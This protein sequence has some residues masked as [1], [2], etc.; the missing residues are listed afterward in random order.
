MLLW[1]P[2][3][4]SSPAAPGGVQPSLAPF[5][6][7]SGA[8][9]PAAAGRQGLP[10][11]L[12][13]ACLPPAGIPMAQSHV[14]GADA[15]L[16]TRAGAGVTGKSLINSRT[17]GATDSRARARAATTVPMDFQAGILRDGNPMESLEKQLICPIC[18]EMFSKP[19]VILPCQHNLCRKCANDVFQVRK[20]CL[21]PFPP[22]A[23]VLWC[24]GDAH[25]ALEM[26]AV[27]W[28]CSWTPQCASRRL[29]TRTGRAGAV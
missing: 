3:P 14:T 8:G 17:R 28:G 16:D 22:P 4:G 18:L 11:S 23:R 9:L 15:S 13:L 2:L 26:L 5:T 10:Y 6:P 20:G 19:V 21:C 24:C 7:R 25:G 12:S 1:D 27:L 29:P